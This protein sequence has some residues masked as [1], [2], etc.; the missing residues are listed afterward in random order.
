M[1]S[2]KRVALI[3]SCDLSHGITTNSPAGFREEGKQFDETIIK[4]L[5]SHNTSGIATLD[6]ALVEKAAEDGYRPLLLL[7]GALKN[8]NYEF[9]HLAY[10]Y[11]FGVGYLTAE[12]IFS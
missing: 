1:E 7:L 10:E 3:A 2:D 11:P 6:P 8:I 12:F 5:E 4:L 9:K